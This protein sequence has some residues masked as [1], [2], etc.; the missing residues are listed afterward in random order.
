MRIIGGKAKGTKLYTL[1]GENTRPTLDRVRES[2]FNIIQFSIKDSIFLDLFAGSGACGI[3]A[4]S[5]GAKK[6][7]LCD[8]SKQAVEIIKKNIEKT[9]TKEQIEIYQMD[10]EEILQTKIKEKLDILYI[11]P[12]YQT[13]D[14]YLAIKMI[15]QR[16]LI[17]QDSIII[18]E[19]DQEKRIK[20]QFKQLEIEII[21]ERKYGRVQ[22]IF[23][24]AKK[25]K[26]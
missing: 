2:L 15:I 6:A 25:G 4:V 21:D 1:E 22:L 18:V 19:T 20:E 11:D 16:Q 12:P 13:D 8:N 9:H 17:K 24:R 23:L 26:G 10:Y 7:I 5:R 14:A 3:E